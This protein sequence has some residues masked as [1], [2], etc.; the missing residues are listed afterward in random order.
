[1]TKME[2]FGI[3]GL[4]IIPIGEF[5]CFGMTVFR[6]FLAKPGEKALLV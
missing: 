5:F 3:L 6:S 4:H 1:M 2:F